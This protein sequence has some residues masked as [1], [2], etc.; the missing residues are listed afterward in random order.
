MVVG[1]RQYNTLV[2]RPQSYSQHTTALFSLFVAMVVGDLWVNRF[3]FGPFRDVQP[4]TIQPQRAYT[5][6]DRGA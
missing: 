1:C 3:I 4:T 2:I 6:V 5:C